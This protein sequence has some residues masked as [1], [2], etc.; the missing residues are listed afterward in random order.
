MQQDFR[1][2]AFLSEFK[3]V[4]LMRGFIPE[5]LL[6]TEDG[7]QMAWQRA[8][9]GDGDRK[10]VYLSSG[11][12]GDEPAGP[13]TILEMM[14]NGDFCDDYDWM[15]CPALNPGG[16]ALKT[17][18]SR[19]GF[20]LNR[21]YLKNRTQEVAAHTR[22]LKKQ[23]TPDLFVSLHEDWES[24]GFYFYEINLG[25]DD[26]ERARVILDSICPILSP[27]KETEIDD[28]E[29]REC[30][31]IYHGSDPDM[32]DSW[33]EAI[34]LAKSGCPLSFTFETPSQAE[35]AV[36]IKAHMAGLRAAIDYLK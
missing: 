17:R 27:E 18:E 4:A 7:P 3:S 33:P 32:P 8:G 30:G 36:R 19:Q 5:V 10:R 34:F 22:W 12:H 29:V 24:T 6:E 2:P 28:H 35:M 13:L 26:P 31:W 25:E 21:D 11:I 14:R 1:W 16:L 20:D 15:I 23:P 9:T